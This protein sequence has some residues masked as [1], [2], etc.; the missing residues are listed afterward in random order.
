MSLSHEWYSFHSPCVFQLLL[1]EYELQMPVSIYHPLLVMYLS[2]FFGNN[3]NDGDG[4]DHKQQRK[5]RNKASKK[6][7][8]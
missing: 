4:H 6:K 3:K 1:Y 7:T 2:I 5:I 8:C